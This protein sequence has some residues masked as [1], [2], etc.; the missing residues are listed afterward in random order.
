MDNK[1]TEHD[2]NMVQ[3]TNEKVGNNDVPEDT[4]ENNGG[5]IQKRKSV[6]TYVLMSLLNGSGVYEEE[7]NFMYQDTENAHTL[8]S[9]AN[10]H[11]DQS[12]VLEA[13]NSKIMAWY[14]DNPDMMTEEGSVIKFLQDMRVIANLWMDV[15]SSVIV[16]MKGCRVVCANHS[17]I[18]MVTKSNMKLRSNSKVTIC[19]T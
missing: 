12:K 3:S 1:K 18:V 13:E 11:H 14:R 7:F 2:L 10:F 9:G 15:V 6:T 8:D 4:T 16:L 19:I 5:G 17:K